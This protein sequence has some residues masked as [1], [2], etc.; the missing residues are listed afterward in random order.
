M[1][2]GPAQMRKGALATL[3]EL[4]HELMLRVEK[5]IDRELMLKSPVWSGNHVQVLT[6]LGNPTDSAAVVAALQERY[7]IAGWARVD[8]SPA[9]NLGFQRGELPA[10]LV[11][12]LSF[13]ETWP[14]TMPQ[15]DHRDVRAS[16]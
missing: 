8:W 2:V 12:T 5:S 3:S 10:E 15:P 16:R 1:A 4:Q 6:P 9:S 14:P 7:R 11:G 13:Y